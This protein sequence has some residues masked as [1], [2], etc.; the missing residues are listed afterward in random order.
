ML[1][2]PMNP[3]ELEIPE[4]IT[5]VIRSQRYQRPVFRLKK[6]IIVKGERGSRIIFDGI[7]FTLTENSAE[8]SGG[9]QYDNNNTILKI[10]IGDLSELIINHCTFVPGRT[11]Q[12]NL[13]RLLFS[14]ENIPTNSQ[15]VNRLKKYLFDIL[16]E[17]WILGNGVR[18]N[19]E[20]EPDENKIT[21]SPSGTTTPSIIL[22]L[23]AALEG[24][25]VSIKKRGR[26]E[27]DQEYQTIYELP[28]SRIE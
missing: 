8:L 28:K 1:K 19:K 22:E 18:V 10:G 21:V 14:W 12:D 17:E 11:E 25:T 20:E 7:L 15:D 5:M 24:R 27:D 26:E 13:G 4:N 3:L 6:P 23:N 2:N 16:N 9:Q